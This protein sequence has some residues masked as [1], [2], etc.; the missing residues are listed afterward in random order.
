M[1]DPTLGQ[2]LEEDPIGLDGGDEN[3]RRY[4]HNNPVVCT[5]PTGLAESGAP[6]PGQPLPGGGY[7]IIPPTESR[8]MEAD[9]FKKEE[10]QAKLKARIERFKAEMERRVTLGIVAISIPGTEYG[11]CGFCFRVEQAKVHNVQVRRIRSIS[12]PLYLRLLLPAATPDRIRKELTAQVEGQVY[13]FH[14]LPP[15]IE[16][17]L[18]RKRSLD[19]K[20]VIVE[21]DDAVIYPVPDKD[22]RV[23]VTGSAELEIKRGWISPGKGN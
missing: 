8:D 15:G 17:D 5:D 13:E 19:G 21:L 3:L 12:L 11:K 1:Y 22:W 6:R 7:F 23:G 4:C 2:F 10:A 14:N 9:S 18:S 20:R 16:C